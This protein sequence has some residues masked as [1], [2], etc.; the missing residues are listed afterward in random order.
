MDRRSFLAGSSLSVLPLLVCPG[1][2][3]ATQATPVVEVEEAL[4]ELAVTLTDTGFEI[5]QPLQAGRYQVTVTNTGTLTDSHFAL[6]TIPDD[7]TDAQFTAFLAAMDDTEDLSFEEIAFVGVPDW[8]PRGGSVSGVIDLVLGQYLLFDPFAGRTPETITVEGDAEAGELA[9]KPA[10]AMTIELREMDFVFPETAITS[11]PQRWKITN[12]GAISHDLAVLP[13]GP[14]MTEETFGHMLEVMMSLPPDATPPPDMPEFIYQ[15]VAAIG[16]L[17][18][19]L[20]SW[21]D[22]QLA[23]GRYLAVCMLPFGTGYPHAMDGMYRVFEV[24]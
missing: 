7:V 20:T 10:A 12:T 17:A 13:V 2:T 23:P 14:E 22:V 24:A 21:L 19:Q 4:P 11:A 3:W 6:G 15:P 8:P 16:I 9:V 18:P 1:R 5:P